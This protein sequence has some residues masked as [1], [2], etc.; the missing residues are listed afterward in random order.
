MPFHKIDINVRL[1]HRYFVYMYNL[2]NSEMHVIVFYEIRIS[3]LIH[4][5]LAEVSEMTW[6]SFLNSDNLTPIKNLLN[7]AAK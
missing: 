3:S 1:F 6:I 4:K 5:E 7:S 2:L